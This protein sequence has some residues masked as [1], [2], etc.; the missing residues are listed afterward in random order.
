[1]A[2]LKRREMVFKAL[3]SRIFFKP[4]KLKQGAGLKI[5]TP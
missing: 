5:S 4:E 3:E 1:M 2:L